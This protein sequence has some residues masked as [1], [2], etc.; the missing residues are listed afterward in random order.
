MP[1][2]FILWAHNLL[3]VA[4]KLTSFAAFYWHWKYADLFLHMLGE[5]SFSNEG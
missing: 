5:K 1:N 4:A 2:V 3:A